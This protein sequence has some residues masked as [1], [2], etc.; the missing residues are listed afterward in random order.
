MEALTTIWYFNDTISK[1]LRVKDTVISTAETRLAE[2]K[3]ADP[4][5]FFQI[6]NKHPTKKPHLA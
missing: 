3:S 5:K 1:W 4:S 2:L 6:S